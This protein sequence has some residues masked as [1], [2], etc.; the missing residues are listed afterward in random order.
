[1]SSESGKKRAEHGKDGGQ[2]YS[3]ED[4]SW[5]N[6]GQSDRNRQDRKTLRTNSV[7]DYSMKTPSKVKEGWYYTS[8]L[9]FYLKMQE[10]LC[11]YEMWS[12]CWK[13]S[14]W[15]RAKRNDQKRS[16]CKGK[17]ICDRMPWIERLARGGIYR[18]Q[19]RGMTKKECMLID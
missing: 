11:L 9:Y 1:M 14:W 3:N 16:P 19:G 8:W 6:T 4:Q 15:L 10:A 2:C 5:Q 18:H 7:V 17:E 13:E 12:I